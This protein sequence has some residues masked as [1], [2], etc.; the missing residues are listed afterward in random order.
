[1]GTRSSCRRGTQHG[2]RQAQLRC[3]CLPLGTEPWVALGPPQP[4]VGT[5][6]CGGLGHGRASEG[7]PSRSCRLAVAPGCVGLQA[8][9]T[10]ATADHVSGRSWPP[11]PHPVTATTVSAGI[12][13]EAAVDLAV[14]LCPVSGLSC[15]S[16]PAFPGRAVAFSPGPGAV[17]A[18][19]VCVRAHVCMHVC[20]CVRSCLCVCACGCVCV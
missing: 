3:R 14:G 1:M 8:A 17:R 5:L 16:A 19:R 7:R 13:W 9:L 18:P 11:C 12:R 6:Y 10:R 20:S 2:S 15:W 4:I